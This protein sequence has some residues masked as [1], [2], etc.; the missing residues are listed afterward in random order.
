MIAALLISLKLALVTTTILLALAVPL[1]WSLAF[2]RFAGCAWLEVLVALPLVL[3]PTVLGYYVLVLIAPDGLIGRAWGMLFDGTLA[4]SFAGMVA[5]SVLYSLPFAVQPLVQAFRSLP[6]DWLELGRMQGLGGWRLWRGIVLPASRGG[7][8]V[9]AG[10]SFA[11]TMGEFGAVLMVGGAIPGET[12]V[13]S[14][15][16]FEF[17]EMQRGE[18]AALLALVLLAMSLA[19]LSLVWRWQGRPEPALGGRT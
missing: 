3:P 18:E 17:V 7:M 12:K 11:H 8:M 6:R 19:V 14:I 13:A 10:L 15:A 16:L 9:A 2:R 4:F 5:A 1:A